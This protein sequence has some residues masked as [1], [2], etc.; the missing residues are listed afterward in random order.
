[1]LKEYITDESGV[2]KSVIINYQFY[3]EIEDIIDDYM[4]GKILEEAEN[5]DEIS[6]EEAKSLIGI[7]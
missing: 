2:I 7:V 6:F 1:M 3:K 5:D 4:L